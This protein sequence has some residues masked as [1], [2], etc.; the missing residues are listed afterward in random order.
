MSELRGEDLQLKAFQCED[1]VFKLFQL[2]DVLKESCSVWKPPDFV[3]G[4]QSVILEE[5]GTA[6]TPGGLMC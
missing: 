1:L 6:R 5:E 3:L 4:S 2:F